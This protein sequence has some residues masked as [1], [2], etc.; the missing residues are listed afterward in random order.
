MRGRIDDR[1]LDH[2]NPA[3][4]EALAAALDDGR[5]VPPFTTAKVQQAGLKG[6]ACNLL[7]GLSQLDD[8]VPPAGM[9]WMLRR[10]ARER[11]EADRRWASVAQL[12]WSGPREGHEPTRDT[13]LVLAELFAKA[14]RHV[15]VSTFVVYDGRKVFEPLVRRMEERPDMVVEFYVN[16]GSKTG[17][18]SNEDDEVA[19]F[20]AAFLGQQWPEGSRAPE[21][22]YDPETRKLGQKRVTLH[23]KCVVIDERWAFVTSANFTEAAQA[24]NIE[25]GVLLDHPG[26]AGALAGRFRAL[27]EAGKMKRMRT[28]SAPRGT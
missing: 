7:V 10:L 4:L 22:Y 16:L 2:A 6:E 13:R 23:A 3:D 8:G 1:W 20:V 25:A 19:R 27:R 17:D 21:L 11:R 9:A 24:R 18:D 26:L 15:L 28:E 5:L 14:E 12:V